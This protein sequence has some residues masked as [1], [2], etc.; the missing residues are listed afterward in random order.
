M[1]GTRGS[2]PTHLSGAALPTDT[3][4]SAT[5][6]PLAPSHN[7][8]ATHRCWLQG[9]PVWRR[10]RQ[11]DQ[12]RRGPVLRVPQRPLHLQLCQPALVCGAAAAAQGLPAAA[13]A[14][15]GG[16]AADARTAGWAAAAARAAGLGSCR[17]KQQQQRQQQQQQAGGGGEQGGAAVDRGGAGQGLACLQGRRADPV[18]L[19]VC[20]CAACAALPQAHACVPAHAG[21]SQQ[22]AQLQCTLSELHPLHP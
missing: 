20:L 11:R 14:A 16:R 6:R 17:H 1:G 8:A 10:E 18:P 12:A 21:T 2:C 19:Q 7:T 13:A 5:P 15:A 22:A 9:V 3:L 4:R